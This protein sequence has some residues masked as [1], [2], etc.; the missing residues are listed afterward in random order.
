MDKVL[1]AT[2][3]YPSLSEVNDMSQKYE[4]T[5]GNL[6]NDTIDELELVKAKKKT[7]SL[8]LLL[9]LSFQLK[10]WMQQ[11]IRGILK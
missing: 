5:L 1:Y 4:V 3:Y 6:N 8:S 7:L 10:L 9:V 2:L 11:E